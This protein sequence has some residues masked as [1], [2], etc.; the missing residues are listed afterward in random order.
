M[1]VKVT[2]DFVI[3]E[4]SKAYNIPG[5]YKLKELNILCPFH[6][7]RNPS[8][9]IS[10]GEKV[11][12]GIFK[13]WSCGESGS[14]N[15][16]ASKVGLTTVDEDEFNIYS[17]YWPT[18]KN[19]IENDVSTDVDNLNLQKLTFSW[20]GFPKRFLHRFGGKLL[21]DETLND[22]FIYLPINYL[23][24]Y[25]GYV[26]CK[27]YKDSPGPK[28]WFNLIQK[29]FY[30]YNMFLN[31]DTDTVVLVEGV[32][33][34][35]RL[36]MYGIPTLATLGTQWPTEIGVD[37]LENLG[38]KKVIFCYD[39]DKAGYEAVIVGSTNKKGYAIELTKNNFEVRVLFPPKG[40]D[41]Y[42]MPKYYIYG[43]A[44]LFKKLK[45]NLLTWKDITGVY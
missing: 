32:T 27:I 13:C 44:Y 42:S 30:P 19:K 16:L 5:I 26:R 21:W 31:I 10:L 38:I 6:N 35:L 29:I 9:S 8:L 33:D 45:G 39:G 37:I 3:N 11:P 23:S 22:T 12:P 40:E 20:R 28:Y 18:I 2:K 15:K 34:A 1:G 25:Y 14:W 43:L 24:D 17:T 41:P 36:I 7:D 4:I